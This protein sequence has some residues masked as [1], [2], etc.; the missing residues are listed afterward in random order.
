MVVT[1]DNI[2]LRIAAVRALRFIPGQKTDNIIA[3]AMTTEPS[4]SVRR[5][6]LLA[7][8]YRTRK[9]LTEALQ[10]VARSDPNDD[11]RKEAAKLLHD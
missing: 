2:R 7:A 1:S 9:P 8:S 3:Q 10:Q 11:I 4:T 6:A 5:A